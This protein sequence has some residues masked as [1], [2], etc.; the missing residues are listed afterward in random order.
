MGSEMLRL[1]IR[2]QSD[3][4]TRSKREDFW[5]CLNR[6]NSLRNIVIIEHISKKRIR[7][8]ARGVTVCFPFDTGII[9]ISNN[10]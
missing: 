9:K 2:L 5:L 10:Y 4:K 7:K 1:E 3:I 6:V 8:R